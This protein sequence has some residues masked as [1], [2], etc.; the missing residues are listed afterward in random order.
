MRE[1]G[2][3]SYGSRGKGEGSVLLGWRIKF[4]GEESVYKVGWQKFLS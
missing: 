3:F 1:I 2:A 4:N